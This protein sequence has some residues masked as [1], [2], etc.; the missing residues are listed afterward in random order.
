[1]VKLFF[2][3][4]TVAGQDA[5]QGESLQDEPGLRGKG[6]EKIDP[7]TLSP[8]SGGIFDSVLPDGSS[9]PIKGEETSPRRPWGE[10]DG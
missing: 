3:E 9:T 1:M 6:R 5:L 8:A 7:I 4:A 10:P 2:G